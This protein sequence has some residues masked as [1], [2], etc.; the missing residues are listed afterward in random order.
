MKEKRFEIELSNEAEED[1]DKAYN[2]YFQESERVANNFYYK[3]DKSF[4]ALIQNPFGYQKV[5]KDVRRFVMKKFPFV[6]YYRIK[7][8]FVKIIA[9]FH[10]SRNPQIWQDRADEE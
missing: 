2:Y 4:K 5:Y 3:T 1:F 7:G 9:I 6:I 8:I 10:T